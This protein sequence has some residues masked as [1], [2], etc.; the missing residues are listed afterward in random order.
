M[1]IAKIMEVKLVLGYL[2]NCAE[3][4]GT[5]VIFYCTVSTVFPQ[6]DA[7]ASISELCVVGPGVKR[8]RAINLNIEF[9][10]RLERIT[11]T[12]PGIKMSI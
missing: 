11:S 12:P 10:R 6:L 1:H 8:S 7:W 4:N 5:V 9:C 2:N 3:Y